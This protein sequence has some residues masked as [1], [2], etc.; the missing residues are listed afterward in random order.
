MINSSPFSFATK[1]D[2][3]SE[4]Y[5]SSGFTTQPK[6]ITIT[7]EETSS[8]DEE[9]STPS[10]IELISY[11]NTPNT[12]VDFDITLS[13]NRTD[14]NPTHTTHNRTN[15]NPMHRRISSHSR[16]MS[17]LTAL[18]LHSGDFNLSSS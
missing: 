11:S 14:S 9:D 4:E 1:K 17:G 8:S 5:S 6:S 16:T 10:E 7:F 12:I 15:S 18:Q 2:N 13:H 3:K